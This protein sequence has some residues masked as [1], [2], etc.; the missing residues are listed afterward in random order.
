MAGYDDN[1]VAPGDGKR[2]PNAAFIVILVGAIVLVVLAGLAAVSL[3]SSPNEALEPAP[4][5]AAESPTPLQTPSP[6]GINSG[7]GATIARVITPQIK[8]YEEASDSAQVKV[9][10][11]KK[12]E[13]GVDQVFLVQETRGTWL[14]VLLP[15]RPNGS[16][17]WIRVRDVKI[18]G[19]NYRLKIHVG[20]KR[21][22]LYES[23]TP[24]SQYPIAVGKQNTPTPGGEYYIKELIKPTKPDGPYG[25]YAYGLNGFSN[26]LESFNGGTGVIGVHGTNDPSS[27]GKEV[28]AGCIRMRNEDIE[29]L[30]ALLPLGTPV[31][32]VAD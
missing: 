3:T 12:N 21:I 27:V 23:G 24:I 16:K 17:G 6:S 18:T 26:V 30:V 31:E 5:T 25:T 20:E 4:T 8:V 13:H 10:L 22:E 19:T 1:F 2:R 7:A 14:H 15:I 11:D 28:S 29:K 9:E 32:I